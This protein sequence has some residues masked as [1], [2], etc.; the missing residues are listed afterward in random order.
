MALAAS[1]RPSSIPLA[2]PLDS[3]L[4]LPTSRPTTRPI[5]APIP[6]PSNTPRA[7]PA[8]RPALPAAASR[9]CGLSSSL[10]SS[11][12][13]PARCT[14]RTTPQS[15]CHPQRAGVEQQLSVSE[16]PQRVEK[17]SWSC[18]G[19]LR[20]LPQHRRQ[21][22]S[23]RADPRRLCPRTPPAPA[24]PRLHQAGGHRR[25]PAGLPASSYGSPNWSRI[26]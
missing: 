5:P 4:A 18:V 12:A 24:K 14:L 21:A 9:P 3:P 17:G 2:S 11:T 26:H 7:P 15:S 22:C 1:K 8:R 25:R 20:R 13:L 10:R 23:R 19:Q 6:T 16:T